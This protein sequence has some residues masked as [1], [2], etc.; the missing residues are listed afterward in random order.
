MSIASAVKKQIKTTL[1]LPANTVRLGKELGRI[2]RY[3]KM[4]KQGYADAEI[5]RADRASGGRP[6]DPNNIDPSDPMVQNRTLANEVRYRRDPK[7]REALKSKS[8]AMRGIK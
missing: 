7:Y 5:L 8:A 4:E 1:A 2:S 6:L 3:R